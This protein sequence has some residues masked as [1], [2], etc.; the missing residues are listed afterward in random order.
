MAPSTL[1]SRELYQNSEIEKDDALPVTFKLCKWKVPKGRK[2]S[3]LTMM[4]STF[5]KHDYSK[6]IRRPIK[7]LT[8]YDPT[9]QQFRGTA[10][11]R[12]PELLQK[13]R[14]KQLSIS[15]LLD[16]ACQRSKEKLLPECQ[17]SGK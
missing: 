15:L 4:E 14:G 10:C 8:D 3:L 17:P 16:P 11:E 13:L 6:P 1:T 2:E 5:Q 9:P 7:Q 12:L